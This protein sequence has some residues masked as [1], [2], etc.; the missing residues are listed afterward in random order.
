MCKIMPHKRT[1]S[2]QSRHHASDIVCRQGS[3]L[4]EVRGCGCDRTEAAGIDL[5][6]NQSEQTQEQ[7]FRVKREHPHCIGGGH[8]TGLARFCPCS[9]VYCYPSGFRLPVAKETW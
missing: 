4:A 1:C 8:S 5:A 2:A 3:G 9:K 6:W 7:T